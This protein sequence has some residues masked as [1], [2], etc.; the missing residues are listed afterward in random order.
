MKHYF[1]LLSALVVT[2]CSGSVSDPVSTQTQP[3]VETT[4]TYGAYMLVMG[5]DYNPADLGAYAKTL[6]PIYAK[7]GGEYVAFSTDI[8]IAEGRY[9][10]QSLII[11]GWPSAKD[12]RAFWDSPEYREAIK[13]RDGIGTFDVV[14]VPSLAAPR[15][16]TGSS[17]NE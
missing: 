2:S 16:T 11:S 3:P 15:P 5:K 9:D 13:L 17:S 10:Y 12:A 14:I 7:Y 6:P 8:D 1:A 4:K